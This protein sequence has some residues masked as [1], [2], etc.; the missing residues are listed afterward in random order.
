MVDAIYEQADVRIAPITMSPGPRMTSIE[1]YTLHDRMIDEQLEELNV[2]G[3]VLI[4]GHKKDLI[5]IDSNSTRV[6][7]YGW[8]RDIGDP[9]QPYST[10]HGRYYYDYSHGVRL[11]SRI[12]YMDGHE[13]DLEEIL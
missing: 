12:A 7:I 8:H 13:I 3:N 6:A 11:V 10:V 5:D 1:Y 4:A 2:T 9:I